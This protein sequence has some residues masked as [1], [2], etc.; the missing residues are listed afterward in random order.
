MD[1]EL[2][3]PGGNSPIELF[4]LKPDGV[5][6][7]YVSWLNDAA[8]N[9]FLLSRSA[10]HTLESTRSYVE[11]LLA[12]PHDLFLGIRYRATGRH[13]GNIRLGPVDVARASAPI[14]ILIGSA[15]MWGTGIGSRAIAMLADIARTRL[16]L[17]SLSAGCYVE[18]VGSRKAFEKA[19]FVV[20]TVQKQ[21]G[22]LDGKAQ[23]VV[24]LSRSLL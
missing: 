16:S 8:I 17:A 7:E 14:G 9:R 15:A 18:N 13:I 22:S 24:L 20:A 2:S 12:S 5:T 4:V 11:T 21:A 1:M 10:V 23:D 6:Q 19:G 3:L